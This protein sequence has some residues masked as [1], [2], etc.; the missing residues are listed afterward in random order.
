MDQIGALSP[1]SVVLSIIDLKFSSLISL[2]SLACQYE[3][4]GIIAKRIK[5]KTQIP[6][7]FKFNLET[8]IAPIKE[9]VKTIKVRN[10]QGN[11][12]F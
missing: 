2:Y 12:N 10:L 5:K 4:V 11:W 9:V 8:K 3:V 1:V 6:F 7:L